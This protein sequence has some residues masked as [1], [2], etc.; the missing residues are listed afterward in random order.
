MRGGRRERRGVASTSPAQVL[1]RGER[2]VM[3][4][5]QAQPAPTAPALVSLPATV[6][7]QAEVLDLSSGPRRD[8]P[9]PPRPV[10]SPYTS[11]NLP[12]LPTSNLSQNPAPAHSRPRHEDSARTLVGALRRLGT[13]VN[14]VP[15]NFSVD[16]T[17]SHSPV[18]S[19][20]PSLGRETMVTVARASSEDRRGE[21]SSNWQVRRDRSH[22]DRSSSRSHGDRS[23]SSRS[24]DRSRSHGGDRSS[25][26]S[27]RDRH[28]VI[29]R[30]S[31]RPPSPS[32]PRQSELGLTY[33]SRLS[34][35][36]ALPLA[37]ATRLLSTHSTNTT[38]EADSVREADMFM[39]D[40]ASTSSSTR[41]SGNL[42]DRGDMFAS[43]GER[44][45][46]AIT[47]NAAQIGEVPL[48]VDQAHTLSSDQVVTED[49]ATPPIN[50]PQDQAIPV[51]IASTSTSDYYNPAN[52]T[53]DTADDGG[54]V[55]PT[56]P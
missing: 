49:Q 55:V 43:L 11:H 31:S 35:S 4:G 40:L 17:R 27:H 50:I 52:P 22:R 42:L 51:P 56:I 8:P 26:R 2:M 12:N 1:V 24:H 41:G 29:E 3:G 13:R 39:R 9:P 47:D 37:E 36:I 20:S 33:V 53:E 28:A 19:H 14:L 54:P 48:A 45:H 18:R 30:M 25:S 5:R 10:P 32:L 38:W 16:R 6:P 7:D 44:P 46:S 21:R 23:S 34:P 15:V